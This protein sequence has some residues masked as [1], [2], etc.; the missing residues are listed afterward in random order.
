[1]SIYVQPAT[2]QTKLSSLDTLLRRSGFYNIDGVVKR[3]DPI[4]VKVNLSP[5]SQR[6]Y[7]YGTDP[8][9]ADAVVDILYEMGFTN[10]SLVESEGSYALV[11]HC[12]TP[13]IQGK[14]FGYRH[15]VVNLTKT[16]TTPF[17]FGY[18]STVLLS[19]VMIDA[20][21]IINIPKA[22]NHDLMLMTCCLKNMYG[23]IPTPNKW[24]Q[25]HRRQSGLGVAEV[26]YYVNRTTPVSFNIVD[27]INGIDGDEISLSRERI[28]DFSYFPS[29]RL[30]AGTDPLAIDKYISLKMGYAQNDSPVVEFAASMAG[31][32]DIT[33]SMI[34]GD[35]FS[36]IDGWKQISRFLHWRAKTQDKLPVSVDAMKWGLKQYQYDACPIEQP[37]DGSKRKKDEKN[38]NQ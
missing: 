31:D 32:Y 4:I 18:G 35:D 7:L 14:M 28:I 37:S 27:F 25:F 2:E 8:V 6:T 30:V 16:E 9:I 26:T 5:V 11:Q 10:V 23:S 17:I 38:E 1:M 36:P 19:R 22:K 13:D 24:H 21:F 20:K 33:R 12:M 15:P 29:N 34:D 3:D